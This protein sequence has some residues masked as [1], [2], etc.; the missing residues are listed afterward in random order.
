[1]SKEF[2]RCKTCVTPNTRPRTIINDDGAC[3][4]CLFKRKKKKNKLE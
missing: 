2:Y 4:A 3:S 1:M